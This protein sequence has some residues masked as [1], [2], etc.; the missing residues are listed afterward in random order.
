MEYGIG[1]KVFGDW[2][3]VKELGEGASGKV[4]EIHKTN[5]GITTRS[6]LKVIRVP[7]SASDIKSALSEGMDAL[8]I[9]NYFEGFVVEIAK[10]IDVMSSLKSHPNIV[11][12]EDHSILEREGEIGWDI[13]IRME[14]LTPLTDYLLTHKLGEAEVLKMAKE[15]CSALV[16]CQKK[17]MIHRDIKP[18]NIFV[19]TELDFFK[20][21]DFGVARTIEKTTGGLSR[22]GTEKYMA[23]E[24]YLNKAYGASV[25]VYSLGIVLYTCMNRGRMPFYPFGSA[26][27]YSDRENALGRRMA[28][29]K[30][31]APVEASEWFAAI[32]LKAC[33]Y[34]PKDRYHSAEE[35]L[36]ALNQKEV[37]KAESVPVYT[38]YDVQGLDD[39]EEATV[40]MFA[41]FTEEKSVRQKPE[42][43]EEPKKIQ[44][45]LPEEIPEKILEEMETVIGETEE[46]AEENISTYSVAKNNKKKLAGIIGAVAVG[47]LV[48]SLGVKF[49]SAGEEEK[50]LSDWGT[51]EAKSMDEVLDS[52]ERALLDQIQK[53]LDQ[54]NQAELRGINEESIVYK[55]AQEPEK[56]KSITM[57]DTRKQIVMDT[58]IWQG[59]EDD[60]YINFYTKEGD[61]EYQY[62]MDSYEYIEELDEYGECCLK[63]LLDESTPEY[64][65]YSNE[66]LPLQLPTERNMDQVTLL[67]C[68]VEE[69]EDGGLTKISITIKLKGKKP[70]DDFETL[71]EKYLEGWQ[72]SQ[73]DLN[74]VKDGRKIAEEYVRQDLKMAKEETTQVFVYWLTEE[75][76]LVKSSVEYGKQYSEKAKKAEKDWNRVWIY[77]TQYKEFLKSEESESEA[78]KRTEEYVEEYYNTFAH[79]EGSKTITNYLIGDACEPIPEL[80]T[81]YQETTY[82]EWSVRWN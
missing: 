42:P 23:P 59:S 67:D 73:E 57:I 22:K 63:I 50:L 52:G 11:S 51:E 69:Q 13:L 72:I 38:S 36:Q 31:P 1:T 26:L 75:N 80:P 65:G 34:D 35:M 12:Y 8:S 66:V 81:E 5:R 15:L 33:A 74:L 17:G 41:G 14:L 62:R 78:K 37:R 48:L 4:F 56:S 43:V 55:E 76:Q 40:G 19:N 29:E 70:E 60:P 64:I 7:H 47:V 18:E 25:D 6:A 45:E 2:E 3:I 28:G 30:I 71:V 58:S 77:I 27:S 21:G 32:I 10:E 54:Y 20:I 82:K 16:F 39:Q 24:V 79:I 44:E 9:S 61:A 53:G 68:N 46:T 49:F